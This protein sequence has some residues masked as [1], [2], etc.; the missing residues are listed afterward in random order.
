MARLVEKN[1]KIFCI[2]DNGHEWE[3]VPAITEPLPPPPPTDA[4]RIAALEAENAGLALELVQNQ[5]RFDQME[6]VNADLLFA[7]V[8]KG[9]L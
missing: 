9:V 1:G 6:Q 2:E 5:I 8:D 3:Y 7:L 4:E